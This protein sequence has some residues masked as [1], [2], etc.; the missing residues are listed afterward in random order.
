MEALRNDVLIPIT[1]L[2]HQHNIQAE[3]FFL[4]HQSSDDSDEEAV[5]PI[6]ATYN[7]GDSFRP[8]ICLIITPPNEGPVAI[9][10]LVYTGAS[11]STIHSI[12]LLRS[13]WIPTQASYMSASGT[14]QSQAY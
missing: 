13:C 1:Y 5:F 3:V 11:I 7:P 4:L 9:T 6:Q 2:E 8:R 14:F 12:C 10:A